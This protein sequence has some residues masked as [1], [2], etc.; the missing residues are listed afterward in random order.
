MAQAASFILD[1]PVDPQTDHIRGDAAARI[2]LVEYGD[3]ECPNCKQAAPTLKLLVEH[4]HP[5]VRMVY[6]HFPLVEVHPHAF[7]AAEAAEAAAAQGSFWAM[8]DKLF[9][10]T[11]EATFDTLRHYAVEIGLDISR[12]DHEA[13]NDIF[14][15]QIETHMKSGKKSGVRSTPGI[16]VDGSL[17]DVSFGIGGLY[18]AVGKALAALDLAP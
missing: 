12:F 17:Y 4:F 6:R 10:G 8:H 1:R 16:F 2:T 5:N 11:L 18:K 15:P 9:A 14:R 7:A 3:F 13:R